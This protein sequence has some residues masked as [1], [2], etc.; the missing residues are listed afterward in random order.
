MIHRQT[1]EAD[2]SNHI[3]SA[4]GRKISPLLTS[5]AHPHEQKIVTIYITRGTKKIFDPFSFCPPKNMDFLGPINFRPPP[6]I[7]G[8]RKLKGIRFVYMFIY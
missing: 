3:R 5:L 1:D 6:K 2:I 4:N 8:G 7:E